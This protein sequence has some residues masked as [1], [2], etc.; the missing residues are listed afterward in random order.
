MSIFSGE[1]RRGLSRMYSDKEVRLVKAA[2]EKT[3][4][5]NAV[6]NYQRLH[7]EGLVKEVGSGGLVVLTE[8]GKTA[9]K[10]LRDRL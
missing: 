6:K 1:L 9:C 3:L 10:V 8:L 7:D 5:A 4:R 2:K